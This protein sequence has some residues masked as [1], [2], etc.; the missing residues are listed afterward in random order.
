MP[1]TEYDI[2]RRLYYDACKFQVP[3]FIVN[4]G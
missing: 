1:S 2:P 4:D 3:V